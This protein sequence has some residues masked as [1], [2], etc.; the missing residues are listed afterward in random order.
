[1]LSLQSELRRRLLTFFYVNRKARVY[2]RQLAQTLEADSTNLS[3]ELAR[4]EQEGLLRAE[5]EGRQL[6]YS[7]NPSS[8]L[9]K[10]LFAL[11][12]GS[13]G[14]VP[15]LKRALR[16]VHGIRAAWL[17]GSFA[18]NEA[19]AASDIDLLL[20]GQPDQAQL[21]VEVRKAERALRR[22]I[23]YT[24]LSAKEL[25]KRLKKGD[26]FIADIW[27]GKRVEL[28]GDRQDKTAKGRSQ[29]G[30]TVSR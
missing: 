27:K 22:E 8:P 10:P 15:A 4:L 26:P 16:T 3:R 11:L 17:Y 25:E 21:A 29:A 9:L 6:Y 5:P 1:M 12:Q 28:I 14:V 24:V 23:N 20:V 13:I 7:V 18:K 19:D 2:V 30:Q